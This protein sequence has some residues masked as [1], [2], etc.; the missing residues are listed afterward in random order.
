M[1]RPKNGVLWVEAM[2]LA[3]PYHPLIHLKLWIGFLLKLNLVG[4]RYTM[5]F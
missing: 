3:G 4:P 2:V 1:G 5:E